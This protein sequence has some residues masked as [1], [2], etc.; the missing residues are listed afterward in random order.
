[1][2]RIAGMGI[3]LVAAAAALG[4]SNLA[5]AQKCVPDCRDGFVCVEGKCVSACNPACADGER[6]SGDGFCVADTSQ[7]P[8]DS[9]TSEGNQDLRMA[10]RLHVI[11]RLG[12]GGVVERFNDIP[13]LTDDAAATVGL[14]LRFEAPVHKVLTTGFLWSFY[15]FAGANAE[16]RS[17]GMDLSP[18]LKGRYAF[19]MGKKNIEGEAYVL[20]QFGVSIANVPD[21]DLIDYTTFG[22]GFNTA[23]TPGF[24]VWPS[25]KVGTFFE[26]GYAY[27]WGRFGGALTGTLGQAAIRFGVAFAFY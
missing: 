22:Y 6:C 27:G 4:T 18:F 13:D 9:V 19:A 7:G 1:M 16:S 15:T 25:D 24:L 21:N 8:R 2:E 3:A 5:W 20:F 17:L 14:T 23:I 11:L 12:A 10:N 26:V